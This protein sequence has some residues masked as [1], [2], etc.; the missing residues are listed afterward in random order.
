M[1]NVQCPFQH[2]NYQ[3][4]KFIGAIL[5]QECGTDQATRDAFLKTCQFKAPFRMDRA[6]CAHEPWLCEIKGCPKQHLM[7]TTKPASI[8]HYQD[9]LRP[10]ITGTLKPALSHHVTHVQNMW[11]GRG[12]QQ[13][14]L[15]VEVVHSP[16]MRV[17]Y[18]QRR[19]EIER[20]LGT[21]AEEIEAFHGTPATNIQLIVNGGFSA[22]PQH[23]GGAAYGVGTYLAQ[24]PA[25]SVSYCRGGKQMFLCRVL[26][27]PTEDKFVP[28]CQ[29]FV[30]KD[31]SSCLPL[32]LITFQ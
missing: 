31:A 9:T 23:R 10:K 15:K 21:S 27:H 16:G 13:Q 20:S 29:Y 12:C 24:N 7:T 5:S 17:V 32:Y 19:K 3:S 6:V 4:I 26:L 22:A 14:I 11:T 18:E 2:P 1:S 8:A 28:G 30:I 25:V